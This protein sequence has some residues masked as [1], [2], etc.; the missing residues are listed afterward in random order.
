MPADGYTPYAAVVPPPEPPDNQGGIGLTP[1]GY[2]DGVSAPAPIGLTPEGYAVGSSAPPPQAPPPIGFT[3]E[4]YAVGSSAPPPQAPPRIGLTPEGYAVGSSAP[5][6]QAPPPIGLTPE[7]YAVGSSAPPQKT[8]LI[9]G[10]LE[11]AGAATTEGAQTLTGNAFADDPNAAPP[12]DRSWFNELGYGFGHSYP[13]AAA[14]VAAGV[15]GLAVGGPIGGIVAGA[16]AMGLAALAQELRPAYL[17]ATQQ[18]LSHDDAVRAAVEQGV[19]TGAV[20]GATAPLFA[21]APFES[22][23]GKALFTS[24]VTAP[25]AGAAARVAVPAL[26]GQPEP[27]MGQLVSGYGQDALGALAFAAGH[28]AYHAVRGEP[29]PLP[30]YGSE[31]DVAVRAALTPTGAPSA[32]EQVM[33]PET[34]PAA[35]PPPAPPPAP[36]EP[37]PAVPPVAEPSAPVA[38]PERSAPPPA[39]PDQAE[40]TTTVSTAAPAAVPSVS[41]TPAPAPGAAAETRGVPPDTSPPPPA[42]PPEVPPP[43][44]PEIAAPLMPSA[45]PVT[46]PPDDGSDTTARGPGPAET[47]GAEHPQGVQP[48]GEPAQAVGGPDTRGLPPDTQAPGQAPGAETAG[49]AP[50]T[51]TVD[52]PHPASIG[53]RID[54]LEQLGASRTPE[55]TAQLQAL[56]QQRAAAGQASPELAAK[57]DQLSQ[58]NNQITAL[59]AQEQKAS[60]RKNNAIQ[61]SKALIA[62]RDELD[63]LKQQRGALQSDITAAQPIERQRYNQAVYGEP[64]LPVERA[65]A[66]GAPALADRS[67]APGLRDAN[68]TGPAIDQALTTE[69]DHE[70]PGQHV[71]KN[72]AGQV[73]GLGDTPEQ[74]LDMARQRQAA[75]ENPAA[76]PT[77]G[78]ET[79]TR[80]DTGPASTQTVPKLRSDETGTSPAG[81]AAGPAGPEPVKDLTETQQQPALDPNSQLGKLTTTRDALLEATPPGKTRSGQQEG[82]IQRLNDQIAKQRKVQN[83]PPETP[84]LLAAR[85]G[86]QKFVPKPGEAKTGGPRVA[87]IKQP[88]LGPPRVGQDPVMDKY[89]F[90]NGTSVYRSVFAQAGH[91]PDVMINRPIKEQNDILRQHMQDVFGFK[92]VRQS[93]DTTPVDAKNNR[94]AML[95]ATRAIQDMMASLNQPHKNASLDGRLSL[96][97]EPEGKRNYAGA[98]DPRTNE[99]LLTGGANSFGHEW[100]HARDHFLAER[101]LNHPQRANLLSR[102]AKQ[103]VLDPKDGIMGAFAKVMNSIFYDKS[104]QALR[105]LAL[106]REAAQTDK[107]GAPTKAALEAQ[108]QIDLLARAGSKLAITPSEFRAAALRSADP[109]YLR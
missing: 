18:G 72:A 27:S 16:G 45:E 35:E 43:S 53:A 78:D 46:P 79:G 44:R 87:G 69:P 23:L 99:I 85:R 83:L 75:R 1:E 33:A 59:E 89:R 17:Q 52:N 86:A 108:R 19:A 80:S 73:V 97:F 26:T 49:V 60:A 6:P 24:F 15:G 2:A 39:P 36:P 12:A 94:D 32:T 38:E 98:Y 29:P 82:R 47:L 4:G 96:T 31:P 100:I 65:K 106:S 92:E 34:V 5:A 84:G 64:K 74:A 51:Y 67:A 91:D 63:A 48:A 57:Q 81:E 105:E 101:L 90:N 37:P 107:T 70:V 11:G 102:Y 13:T 40:P 30:A 42:T 8:G 9:S 10:L 50:S 56:H 95:D 7:G 93:A 21:Y 41:E 88:Y 76:I 62:Q 14:G 25:A 66:A 109:R 22:M 104:A 77:D 54:Q 71:A 3:P 28:G 61:P 20:T 103:G 58:L 68:E 55:Q